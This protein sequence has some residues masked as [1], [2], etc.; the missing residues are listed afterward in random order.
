VIVNELAALE[1]FLPGGVEG[2]EQAASARVRRL[3]GRQSTQ[4]PAAEEQAQGAEVGSGMR[5]VAPPVQSFAMGRR[6]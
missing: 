6:R 4:S 5:A 1:R 3:P 2:E